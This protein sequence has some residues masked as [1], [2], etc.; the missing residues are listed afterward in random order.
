MSSPALIALR[1]WLAIAI[2]LVE[3]SALVGCVTPEPTGDGGASFADAA[4]ASDVGAP[5]DAVLDAALD[6][7]RAPDAGP[8]DD[9]AGA[10]AYWASVGSLAGVAALAADDEHRLVVTVGMASATASVDAHTLFNVAS[11]SKTFTGAMILAL[12]EEGLLDLDAPLSEVMPDV[13]VVHPRFPARAITTRML[14]THTSGIL[15][16]FLVLGDYTSLGAEDPSVSLEAFARAYLA[17]EGHFGP[18]PG[19]SREYCNA[20]FGLLGL[21]V[22][23][24]SGRR[25]ADVAAEVLGPL[26][27]DG[28]SFFFADVDP[29][30]LAAPYA[31]SG[32][33]YAELPQRGYAFYPA[34]SMMVSLVGVERF[35]R[36]HLDDGV[37]DGE[38]FFE[39]ASIAETR[40]IQFPELD[41][42]QAL[43]W[44]TQSTRGARFYGHSGSSFGSSAQMRYRP[45]SRRLLIVLSNSDAYV[46]SR[47][48][49]PAG[50]DAIDAIL[51]RLDRALDA[52]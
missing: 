13:P 8:P 27:L 26:D 38:R 33:G 14:L 12:A 41:P 3:G 39:A 32:R 6:A 29:A 16:D 45:E 49:Q 22:E 46:R 36:L 15:D 19:T 40:R 24:A 7:S 51:D 28:A 44:S 52:P 9:L 35:L 2:A 47:F 34:T 42:R 43:V 37:L 25:F 31:K 17:D 18:E 5:L 21:V 30:R 48:G 20:C 11:L 23:R 1:A 4:V 50:A 10:I